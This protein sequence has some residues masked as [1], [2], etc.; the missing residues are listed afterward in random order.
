LAAAVANVYRRH[1][2]AFRID[3]PGDM[4][5]VHYVQSFNESLV[6]SDSPAPCVI[7]AAGGMCE[8]GRIIQH[9]VRNVSDPGACIVLVSF[10]APR[11][12]GR[13]LLER[14]PTVHIMGRDYPLRAE[15]IHLQGFSSHADHDD[16]MAQLTPL[17]GTGSRL[18]LIHGEPAA[19]EALEADLRA[20]GITDVG[21]PDAGDR[22]ELRRVTT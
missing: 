9:L 21:H 10:Q 17:A 12:L 19:A 3:L 2:E 22:E 1:V 8:G 4:N 18:R 15:V 14:P 7:I 11:T 5:R 16:L 13:Q 6:L 20:H